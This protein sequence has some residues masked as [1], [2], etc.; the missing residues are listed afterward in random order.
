M[1]CFLDKY[2]DKNDSPLRHLLKHTNERL[3]QLICSLE[4]QQL[5]NEQDQVPKE[6]FRLQE[7]MNHILWEIE[8]LRFKRDI[9]ANQIKHVQELLAPLEK[10]LA[11]INWTFSN[12][13]SILSLQEEMERAYSTLHDFI[14][15]LED[16]VDM[17]GTVDWF[18]TERLAEIEEDEL[19]LIDP[20]LHRIY[21]ALKRIVSR[22]NEIDKV[23]MQY[24]SMRVV[25]H[26]QNQLATI[27]NLFQDGHVNVHQNKLHHVP[28]I[29]KGQAILTE[30][31]DEA[32]ER[33]RELVQ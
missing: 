7:M 9:T 25:G 2:G 30:I 16:H 29:P 20:K 12:Q 27:T 15:K 22:L 4:T 17:Q 32:H 21:F 13:K 10:K 11:E 19:A 26:L 24:R 28:D 31:V 1:R 18:K 6:A 8:D 33:A 14:C 23:P 3:C 5:K